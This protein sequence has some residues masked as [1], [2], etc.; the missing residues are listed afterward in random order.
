MLYSDIVKN[1][2]ILPRKEKYTLKDVKDL[3]IDSLFNKTGGTL[4]EKEALF[5]VKCS[6]VYHGTDWSNTLRKR[7]KLTVY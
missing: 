6:A 7:K 1:G 2:M 3:I 4:T 5:I